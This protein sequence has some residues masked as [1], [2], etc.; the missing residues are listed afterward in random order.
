[1]LARGG[2]RGPG[3]RIVS[4]PRVLVKFIFRELP[5]EGTVTQAL[6]NSTSDLKRCARHVEQLAQQVL[7]RHSHFQNRAGDFEYEYRQG[8]LIV[9]GRLPTFYLKQVLQTVLKDIE[10]VVCIDNQV[11]VVSSEGVSSVRWRSTLSAG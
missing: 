7:A 4:L 9:R 5:Q 11:D 2:I 6:E 8:V 10:G 3:Q 1:M